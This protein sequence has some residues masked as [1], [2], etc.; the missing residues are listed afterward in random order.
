MQPK[1][2]WET[3]IEMINN[4]SD[5]NPGVQFSKLDKVLL[6][7]YWSGMDEQEIL[8]VLKANRSEFNYYYN[9]CYFRQGFQPDVMK[10]LSKL[11]GEAVKKKLL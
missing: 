6:K 4:M 3:F 5:G 2:N 1:F 10:K 7:C 9:D 11:I 8:R